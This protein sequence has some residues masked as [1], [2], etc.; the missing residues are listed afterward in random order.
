[1]DQGDLVVEVVIEVDQVLEVQVTHLLQTHL[2]VILVQKQL[3][4]Q[5]LAVVEQLLQDQEVLAQQVEMEVQEH[6]TQF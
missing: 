5:E 2:K 4:L 3:N 6:L 1:V